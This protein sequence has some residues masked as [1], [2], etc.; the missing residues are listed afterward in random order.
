MIFGDGRSAKFIESNL[1]F[2]NVLVIRRY[3]NI[4]IGSSSWST[5]DSNRPTTE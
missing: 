3:E 2:R 1:Q 4:Q 5:I